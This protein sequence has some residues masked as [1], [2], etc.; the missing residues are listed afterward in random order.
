MTLH[1][2]GQSKNSQKVLPRRLLVDVTVTLILAAAITNTVVKQVKRLVCAL[3]FGPFA[4]NMYK[5]NVYGKDVQK[6]N[7]NQIK[8]DK[9]L[10]LFC[11]YI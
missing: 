11:V 6:R 9:G 2:R 3:P 7:R 1:G 4:E 10:Q 5:R 8:H